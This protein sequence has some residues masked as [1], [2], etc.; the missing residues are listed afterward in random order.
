VVEALDEPLDDSTMLTTL[1][2]A[3]EY[4]VKDSREGRAYQGAC[5]D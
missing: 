1:R 5:E 4:L 2:E 3:I